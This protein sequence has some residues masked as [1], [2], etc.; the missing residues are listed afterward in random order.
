[1]ILSRTPL[2]ISFVGGGTDI[3]TFYRRYGGQVISTAIDKY[4]SVI[5]QKRKG[6]Q[7]FINAWPYHQ[8]VSSID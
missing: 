8:I 3:P 6:S 2:R 7:I 1:M 4:I 5:I